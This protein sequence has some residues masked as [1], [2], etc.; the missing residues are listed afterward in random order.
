M[1]AGKVKAEYEDVA[2]AARRTGASVRELSFRAEAR[3]REEQARDHDDDDGG[4]PG[5]GRGDTGPGGTGGGGGA[6]A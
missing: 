4:L 6:T 3:W 1:A 5:S 2:Q